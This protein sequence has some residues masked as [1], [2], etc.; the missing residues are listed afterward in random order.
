MKYDEKEVFFTTQVK[1]VRLCPN[2]FSRI[3][4]LELIEILNKVYLHNF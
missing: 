3:N 2:I 4:I 1:I